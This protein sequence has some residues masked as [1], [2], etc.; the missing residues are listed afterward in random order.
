MEQINY[1]N[2]KRRSWT[3]QMIYFFLMMWNVCF[4]YVSDVAWLLM[5]HSCM[6]REI[7]SGDELLSYIG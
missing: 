3:V 1:R 7:V 6:L 2:R 5:W 4:I